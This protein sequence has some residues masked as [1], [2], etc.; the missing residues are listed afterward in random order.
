MHGQDGRGTITV[1]SQQLKSYQFLKR[2]I[3]SPRRGF[4]DRGDRVRGLTPPG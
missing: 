1:N 2:I 4:G 3:L